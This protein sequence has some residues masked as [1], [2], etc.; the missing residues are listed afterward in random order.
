MLI[1]IVYSC[2]KQEGLFVKYATRIKYYFLGTSDWSRDVWTVGHVI[3]RSV[4]IREKCRCALGAL[5]LWLCL[6]EQIVKMIRVLL[7]SLEQWL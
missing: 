7:Y 5:G 2:A 1:T 4:T 3:T 6:K